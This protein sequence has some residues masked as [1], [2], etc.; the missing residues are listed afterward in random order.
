MR[1]IFLSFLFI[2]LSST[3]YAALPAGVHQA[4]TLVGTA[5]A[6]GGVSCII[7][8]SATA[9]VPAVGTASA[10]AGTVSTPVAVP[11]V[12]AGAALA[13]GYYIGS[14]LV[15]DLNDL[16]NAAKDHPDKYPGLKDSL[17]KPVLPDNSAPPPAEGSVVP[18]TDGNRYS[19]SSGWSLFNDNTA[20]SISNVGTY[21]YSNGRILYYQYVSPSICCPDTTS[22]I[23]V[24]S[25]SASPTT[26]PVTVPQ[27]TTDPRTPA[28]AVPNMTN[29]DGTLK[30]DINNEVNQAIANGDVS[31]SIGVSPAQV[32]GYS[33]Q[34]AAQ[35]NVDL[36][37]QAVQDA[38]NRLDLNTDPAAE[39]QLRDALAD[40]MHRLSEAQKDLADKALQNE[41][42]QQASDTATQN[43]PQPNTYDTQIDTPEKKDIPKLLSDAY[44][45]SPITRLIRGFR[46]KIS[47]PVST[48]V[49]GT[50]YG[51]TLTVDFSRWSDAMSI[52]GSML[53]TS[54]Y[55]L[56]V[57][58][59]FKS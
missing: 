9:G 41:D 53:L 58:I 19:I 31:P 29:P 26:N 4:A 21:N 37:R 44:D 42:Y 14:N 38:Q 28:E 54:C 12:V 11:L 49:L 48:V 15:T 56:S 1:Y 33:N 18:A 55:L 57:F 35:N 25:A 36:A 34:V 59:I 24:W 8:A 22:I 5:V 51:K 6:T 43:L 47:N 27:A 39:A 10:A 32:T 2:L 46:L 23:D 30:P 40:A 17:S 7:P 20:T 45:K 16:Y 13:G 50:V 3:S 52:A